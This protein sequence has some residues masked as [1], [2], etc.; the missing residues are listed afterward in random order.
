MTIPTISPSRLLERHR[1]GQ[2]LELIDVRTPAEYEGLHLQFARNIPLDELDPTV[3][4]QARNGSAA[5]PLYVICQSGGRSLKAC[6]KFHQAGFTDV[7]NV[8][9]GTQACATA[10]LPLVHGK[11]ADLARAPGAHRGGEF[12]VDRRDIGL[13]GSPGAVW[14]GGVHRCGLDVCRHHGHLRDGDVAFPHAVEPPL[15]VGC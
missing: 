2:K 1:E 4:M 14:A 3:V 5:E 10:G 15:T 6:Q 13:A 12:G 9:G 7:V 11:Q 8:E